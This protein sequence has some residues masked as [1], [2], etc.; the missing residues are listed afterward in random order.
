MKTILLGA[1]AL[2]IA[3]CTTPDSAFT[4]SPHG[5]VGRV[6][7]IWYD[8]QGVPSIIQNGESAL[9]SAYGPDGVMADMP[10]TF[11]AD[12]AGNVNATGVSAYW[13]AMAAFCRTAPQAPVCGPSIN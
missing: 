12:A 6:D 10:S 13:L 5:Y 7:G 1:V 3:G 9:H 4:G 2:A 8:L 11:S